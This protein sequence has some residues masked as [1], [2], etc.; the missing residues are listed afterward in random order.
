V[1]AIYRERHA[2]STE[3]KAGSP[4]CKLTGCKERAGKLEPLK[5]PEKKGDHVF[6]GKAFCSPD[7]AQ[8]F[9]YL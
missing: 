1:S 4:H 2:S 9:H 3:T 6:N 8:A 5:S 7:N